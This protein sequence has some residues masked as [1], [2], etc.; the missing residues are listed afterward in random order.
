MNQNEIF[1]LQ[2]TEYDMSECNT[3][4]WD[5]IYRSMIFWHN[6]KNETSAS[7]LLSTVSQNV[8]RNKIWKLSKV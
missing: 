8:L 2:M 5:Q 6:Q 7:K 3:Q 1:V 4:I